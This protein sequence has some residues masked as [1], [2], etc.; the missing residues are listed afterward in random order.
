MMQQRSHVPQPRPTTAKYVHVCVCVRMCVCALSCV[1][2]SVTPWTVALQV[3][4][5]MEFSR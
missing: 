5:P 2:L 1:Q 3:T 4:L